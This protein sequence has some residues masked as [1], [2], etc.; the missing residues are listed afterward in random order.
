MDPLF[1]TI[2]IIVLISD[3]KLLSE[4]GHSEHTL[5]RKYF[6][7]LFYSIKSDGDIYNGDKYSNH[8]VFR[9][10]NKTINP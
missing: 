10:S 3:S 6:P 5:D 9:S 2:V 7:Y 4:I 8:L 1:F